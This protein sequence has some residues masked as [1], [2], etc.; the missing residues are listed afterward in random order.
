MLLPWTGICRWLITEQPPITAT[1]V[2]DDICGNPWKKWYSQR[3]TTVPNSLKGIRE[4][5]L[6]YR[7]ESIP[8]L[9][10]IPLRRFTEIEG[11]ADP[12]VHEAESIAAAYGIDADLLFDAPGAL[13]PQ[14][15]VAA[16]ASGDDFRHYG[17]V[18]RFRIVKVTRAVRDLGQLRNLLDLP[19]E[20]P[21]KLI[22][23]PEANSEPPY[24]H[25][26][27]AAERIRA[28]L[29]PQSGPIQSMTR[30][31]K[32]KLPGVDLLYANL[33]PGGPAGL[34]FMGHTFGPAIVLNLDGKNVNPCVR[35]FSLAH[36]V[37]HV[38]ADWDPSEPLA[39]L[40]DYVSDGTSLEREQRAN[41][42]ASRFLCPETAMHSREKL[43]DHRL[44]E[45]L[46]TVWGLH[47]S[48]ASLHAKNVLNIKLPPTP[49]PAWETGVDAWDA[50]EKPD[51]ESFP[52]SRVPRE[53][54]TRVAQLA[55]H[56]FS[57]GLIQRDRFAEYLEV[58]PTEDLER[59]LV[60]FGLDMPRAA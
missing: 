17:D 3:V 59:V 2:G 41:G 29:G 50:H 25:G 8:V 18:E 42:F 4:Q 5:L 53:R 52:L 9:T 37:Y 7:L 43:P 51:G 56:A 20:L 12:S 14:D 57:Q 55:A 35:R 1:A 30:W 27:R 49:N 45:E 11:G 39:I 34:T 15:V 22:E 21:P 28:K 13:G 46:I 6:G 60:F 16:L 54:R 32:E 47:Y 40:S 48:A 38:L 10:G 24:A 36:E 44:V 19:R 26:R 31:V 23:R 33:G 58:P